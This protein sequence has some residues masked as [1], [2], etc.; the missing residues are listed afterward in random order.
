M[1]IGL[2]MLSTRPIRLRGAPA[3]VGLQAAALWAPAVLAV[4]ALALAVAAA[5]G[6]RQGPPGTAMPGLDGT[7]RGLYLAVLANLAAIIVLS[8]WQAARTGRVGRQADASAWRGLATPLFAGG[9]WTIA[10]L[11]SVAALY[12]TREALELGGSAPKQPRFATTMEW[13]AVG[14]L[15]AAGLVLVAALVGVAH[16]L[17]LR[18]AETRSLRGQPDPQQHGAHRRARAV[19]G[20]RGVHR[21]VGY[22]AL[23]HVGWLAV[24]IVPLV[25]VVGLVAAGRRVGAANLPA[26]PPALTLFGLRTGL[27]DRPA[28]PWLS[29]GSA[30]ASLVF[31]ALVSLA[32]VTYRYPA[33]R[34]TIGVVWDIV[35][36]W[37]RGAHPFA[38]PCYAE[39]AVPLLVNRIEALP[40][41]PLI[42]AGHSQG[43]LLCAATVA[44]LSPQRRRLT[45]LLTY[46]TQMTRLYGR[47]FPA[48]F[49]PEG[50]QRLAVLLGGD[51]A[52]ADE[53]RG[54]GPRA[55]ATCTG[56]PTCSAGRWPA[57]GTA[58]TRRPSTSVT[59]SVGRWTC[60]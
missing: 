39:R 5:I 31:L 24:L 36:F 53:A 59:S 12:G 4:P 17:R 1:L 29:L 40:E 41:H 50:R 42:L 23:S 37:P 6:T 22:H 2:V 19:G 16:L 14:A 44:Q 25:V 32:L 51:P 54:S 58:G 27:P 52:G 3:P 57:P 45:F 18:A 7:L 49:G 10:L 20:S 47:G 33:V 56:A 48:F 15:A 60:P 21:F 9:G 13:T 28:E 11:Y 35:T 46:G 30:F 8:G 34:R 55:G 43:S 26:D 38:P